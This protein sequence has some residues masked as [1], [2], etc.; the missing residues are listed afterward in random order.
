L[1]VES[2]ETNDEDVANEN[3][4]RNHNIVT[5]FTTNQIVLVVVSVYLLAVSILVG[6]FLALGSEYSDSKVYWAGCLGIISLLTGLVQFMPQVIH[7]ITC[8]DFGALSLPMLLMQCPGSFLFAYSLS[9][10]SGT[11]WTSWI[12][13]LIGGTFQAI[14]ILLYILFKFVLK[15][16]GSTDINEDTEVVLTN[17]S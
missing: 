3:N 6:R 7:T 2:E 11:N 17:S 8:R 13:F 1:L 10:Q 4:N 14:L 5:K 16:V 15:P 12:G 9:I